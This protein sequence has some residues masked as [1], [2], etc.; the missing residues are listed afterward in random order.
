MVRTDFSLL[1]ITDDGFVSL[2]MDNGDTRDDVRLPSQT[3]ED[4]KLA[5]Q[6]RKDFED[7]KDLVLSVLKAL[8]D[9]KIIASKV[10]A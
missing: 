7:G 2:M 9:E 10:S 5:E 3:D 1:D 6:I 4:N 8:D